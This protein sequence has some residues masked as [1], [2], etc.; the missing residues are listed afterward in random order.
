MCKCTKILYHWYQEI[1]F[2]AGVYS[3]ECINH[4]ENGMRHHS[5]KKSFTIV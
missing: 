5:A 1:Y 4:R 3:Y 2:N